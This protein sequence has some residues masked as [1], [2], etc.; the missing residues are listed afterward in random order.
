MPNGEDMDF[1]PIAFLFYSL[2][3]LL[4]SLS[5]TG[6]QILDTVTSG[7]T[8]TTTTLFSFQSNHETLLKVHDVELNSAKDLYIA[9]P[10]IYGILLL[11]LWQSLTSFY[12][13][14]TTMRSLVSMDRPSTSRVFLLFSIYAVTFSLLFLSMIHIN[15]SVFPAVVLV[16][17]LFNLYCSYVFS[18]ALIQKYAAES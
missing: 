13:Y 18:S 11:A 1:F 16:H 14:Y 17:F 4:L 8:L 15:H 2:F 12:R 7:Q 3:V 10:L 5:V 6:V 9:L